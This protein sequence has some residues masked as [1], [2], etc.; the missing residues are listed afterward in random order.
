MK[1]FTTIAIMLI[2]VSCSS[3]KTES[4][5]DFSNIQSTSMDAIHPSPRVVALDTT[6]VI[7]GQSR[8][9]YSN[10]KSRSLDAQIYNTSPNNIVKDTVIIIQPATQP[11]K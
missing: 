2:L 5:Y 11:K 6:T 4:K 7:V 1:L 8:V 3:S 10:I 9:D